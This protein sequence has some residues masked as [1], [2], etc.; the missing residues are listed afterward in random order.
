MHENEYTLGSKAFG[1]EAHS[2]TT[3]KYR[4][5]IDALKAVESAL[6]DTGGISLL[7]GEDGAGKTTILREFALHLASETDVVF[8]DGT[9]LKPHQLLAKILTQLGG[10]VYAGSDDEMLNAVAE[11][12]VEQARSW[13]PPVLIIDN[14]DKMYPSSLRILN[15]LAGV[16]VDTRF[17]LR[18][19]L[20]GHGTLENLID[21]DGMTNLSQRYPGKYTL[22]PLSAKETMIYLHARL[23]AAGSERAD[24]VFPFDVCDRLREQSGG[25]PGRLNTF[26]L[27][28]IKRSSGFPPER[29]RYL[30][31]QGKD[32]RSNRCGSAGV[33]TGQGRK[34]F[35]TA[36]AG[37]ARR[38][39]HQRVHIQGK[40]RCCW[41]ARIS[42]T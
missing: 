22:G 42:S 34:A 24:T 8:I 38:Q 40:E 28:A 19:I 25:W 17:A 6:H 41:V 23:Q 33:A 20:S 12:A 21:S 36:N 10:D 9:Q 27:E 18:L 15:S 13:Q 11:L 30:W 32:S 39:E 31:R 37:N 26:A 2:L 29:R 14:V 3:V 35:T 7:I 1:D 4:S 16:E 5:H